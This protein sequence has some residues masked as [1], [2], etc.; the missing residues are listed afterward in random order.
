MD[1]DF[2]NLTFREIIDGEL[3]KTLASCSLKMVIPPKR[4]F[5]TEGD[6]LNLL[7]YIR[8]GIVTLYMADRN[9][10]EKTL[11]RLTRGWYFGE[12]VA[13]LDIKRTS[14]HFIA[15]EETTLYGIDKHNVEKLMEDNSKFRRSLLQC[16]CYKT[17]ALRYEIANFT[18]CSTKT[19]LLKSLYRDVDTG[20]AID[21]QWYAL[22]QKRTHYELGIDI[23]ATRVT[24]SRLIS[25][26]C[27]EGLLRTV[28]SQIQFSRT[29]YNVMNAEIVDPQSITKI[30][31]P[32]YI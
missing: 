15:N 23:G 26:L 32:Y 14:L 11:Y 12:M 29:L 16:A 3:E 10:A 8:S 22:S 19:R 25:E 9:G 7:Y 1:Y 6:E 28:N 31:D 13:L 24:V 27:C 20:T 30:H 2:K 21:N 5:L 18:F 17:I 4:V